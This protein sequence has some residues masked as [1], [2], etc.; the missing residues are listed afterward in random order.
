RKGL[1]DYGFDLE[2]YKKEMNHK[3]FSEVKV[4]PGTWEMKCYYQQ[5]SDAEIME[6]FGFPVWA[7]LNRK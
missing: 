3:E 1:D 5:R 7:E 2:G 4:N 6:E